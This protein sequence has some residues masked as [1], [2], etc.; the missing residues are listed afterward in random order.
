[1]HES[2]LDEKDEKNRSKLG[3]ASFLMKLTF[4]WMNLLLK[5]GYLKLLDLDDIPALVTE[6]EAN[7]AYQMFSV[8]WD[9]LVREKRTDNTRTTW[10]LRLWQ[11]CISEK[12]Y[13]WVSVFCL[14]QLRKWLFLLLS[15]LL[16]IIQVI[17]N[18]TCIKV[19]YILSSNTC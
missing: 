10:F 19:F 2:L 6:D 5:L 3:K 7:L 14:G 13:S 9:S 16:Q 18:K 1:M 17:M 4:S 8:A 15:M 12:I 11:K